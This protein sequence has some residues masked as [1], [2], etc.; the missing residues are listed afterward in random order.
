VSAIQSDD[1]DQFPSYTLQF[2][3]D[4][5]AGRSG[6]F[7]PFT[8]AG[9][10]NFLA[11]HPWAARQILSNNQHFSKEGVPIYTFVRQF[12]GNGLFTSS[13]ELHQR[14]RRL[15]QPMFHRKHL[16][17]LEPIILQSIEKLLTHWTRLAPGPI[18]FRH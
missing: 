18:S 15:M 6:A 10:S 1:T 11:L 5:A 14:Q 8:L 3:A 4:L 12:F 9:T 2:F 17:M 16:Q 7:V 13:G